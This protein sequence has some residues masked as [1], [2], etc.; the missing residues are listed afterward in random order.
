[1][2]LSVSLAGAGSTAV[3]IDALATEV[4]GPIELTLTVP[5]GV[6]LVGSTG[7]WHGCSQ[8]DAT[9]TC[10][11]V[12]QRNGVWSGVVTLGRPDG[13]APG[14]LLVRLAGQTSTGGPAGGSVEVPWPPP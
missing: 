14:T 13:A 12:P 6:S 3:R 5:A 1:V 8:L 10:T 11:G 4:F 9:I 2:W 7:D